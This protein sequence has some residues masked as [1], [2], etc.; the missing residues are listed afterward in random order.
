MSEPAHLL[1]LVLTSTLLDHGSTKA[2]IF[3]PVTANA[4]IKRFINWL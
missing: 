4:M 3:S 1:Q 2:S